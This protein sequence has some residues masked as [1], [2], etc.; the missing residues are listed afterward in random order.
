MIKF[1]VKLTEQVYQLSLT[2]IKL[3]FDSTDKFAMAH[4]SSVVKKLIFL[5]VGNH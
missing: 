2:V 5:S 3:S 4:I 1:F